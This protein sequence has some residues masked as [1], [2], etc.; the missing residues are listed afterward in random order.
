MFLFK[1]KIWSYI[2]H[3]LGFD[4][5]SSETVLYVYVMFYFVN[6][7]III[8]II[9]FCKLIYV[10]FCKFNLLSENKER[11]LWLINA[12]VFTKSNIMGVW[13]ALITPLTG[14]NPGN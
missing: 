10:L 6:Y 3:D 9:V 5:F 1:L 8:I 7:C 12:A 13:R 4:L 2:Q 14:S 11:W